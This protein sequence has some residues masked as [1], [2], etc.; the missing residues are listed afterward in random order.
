MNRMR[1][2]SWLSESYEAATATAL[3][4]LIPNGSC[5][6]HSHLANSGDPNPYPMRSPASPYAFENVRSTTTFGK[7]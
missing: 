4:M 3:V 1:S 5:M 2:H 6:V 7:R